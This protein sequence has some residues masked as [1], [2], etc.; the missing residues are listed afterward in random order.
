[1]DVYKVEYEASWEDAEFWED[2]EKTV[3]ADTATDAIEK[4][5][6]LVLAETTEVDGIVAKREGFRLW[7]VNRITTLDG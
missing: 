2:D 3:T 7:A 5:K 6:A 1:M 4:V